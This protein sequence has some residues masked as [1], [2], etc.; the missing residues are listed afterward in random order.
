MV[1]ELLK[2]KRL[3]SG[4]SQRDVSDKLGYSTPQFISNWERGISCPPIGSLKKLG[5]IYGVS[6]D[7]LFQAMLNS[8]LDQVAQD[9][10]RKFAKSKDQ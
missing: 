9:L 3:A 8:T 1:A 10:R 5:K 2:Q 6:A 4:L 7:D